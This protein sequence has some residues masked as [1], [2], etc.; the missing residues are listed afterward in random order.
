MQLPSAAANCGGSAARARLFCSTCGVHRTGARLLPHMPPP[1]RSSV[2]YTNL[3]RVATDTPPSFRW[4]AARTMMS[5]ALASISFCTCTRTME[6]LDI[7]ARAECGALNA[8]HCGHSHCATAECS[9][10]RRLSDRRATVL[11]PLAMPAAA[12]S[13]LFGVCDC[14]RTPYVFIASARACSND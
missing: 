12:L 1:V 4:C 10:S 14:S 6:P 8:A 3:E 11:P 9:A 13:L 5:G 7:F 2:A